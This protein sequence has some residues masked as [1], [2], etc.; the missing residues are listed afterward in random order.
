MGHG[1]FQTTDEKLRF[2]GYEVKKDKKEKKV[3][4]KKAVEKKAE[5]KK[6]EIKKEEKVEVK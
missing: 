2:Y 1:R 4:E 3:E 6:P 5:E